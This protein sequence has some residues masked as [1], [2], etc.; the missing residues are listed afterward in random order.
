MKKIKLRPIFKANIFLIIFYVLG[1]A[2][3]LL[4]MFSGVVELVI[5]AVIV[6][7]M[8]AVGTGFFLSYGL[9]ITN[10]TVSV[11]YMQDFKFFRYEDISYIKIYFED[12][13]ISGEIKT[14]N[15]KFY[16]FCFYDLELDQFSIFSRLWTIR[17]KMTKKYVE[18]SIENLSKCEKVKIQNNFECELN[19]N[20]K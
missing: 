3:T 16:S 20:P 12:E 15:Q 9:K 2:A 8:F 18:K 19:N 13:C 17:V 5:I 14:K 10:K 4:F 11:I 1:L 7:I 6:M